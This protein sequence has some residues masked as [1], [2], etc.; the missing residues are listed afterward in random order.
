MSSTPRLDLPSALAIL[1]GDLRDLPALEGEREASEA[2]W[3]F[4]QA[5]V[6]GTSIDS[7]RAVWLVLGHSWRRSEFRRDWAAL[8]TRWRDAKPGKQTEDRTG[9]LYRWLRVR[10]KHVSAALRAAVA[11]HHRGAVVPAAGTTAPRFG[12]RR[13]QGKV[14]PVASDAAT[15][16]R[17][18]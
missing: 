7:L 3:R 5:V 16:R 11:A 10:Q 15:R 6:L 17:M 18:R 13:R 14:T 9:D 4:E 2:W 8:A 1:I 12:V